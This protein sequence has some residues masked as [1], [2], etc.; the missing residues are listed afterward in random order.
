MF[1]C[2]WESIECDSCVFLQTQQRLNGWFAAVAHLV[3]LFLAL[4]LACEDFLLLVTLLSKLILIRR[5]MEVTNHESVFI[6]AIHHFVFF[7]QRVDIL[8]Q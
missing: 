4:L 2:E 7:F 8:A 3:E 1:E 5:Q 6:L